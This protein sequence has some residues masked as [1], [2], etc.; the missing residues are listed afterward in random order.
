M[1]TGE[2]YAIEFVSE[3]GKPL[4]HTSKFINQCGVVVRDNVPITV[5]EWKEPK[6]ARLGFSFVDK[7]TKKDC[8]RKLMEHFIL[9]PEY[10]KVDEFGNEVP[11]G[12]QR[13]RL[14]KEFALQ[15]MGEAFRNFKKNLTRDYV[16]KGKTPDFNGQH[17]KLKDDWPEFV[18]QKQSEHFKEISK[19]NKDN[20]SKK[21]FHHIMGPGGY[22]LSEPRWQKMEEDLRVRGIPLGTEGWDPRAKSWW[23]GHGGSLDPETGVCVHRQRQFAPTQALIDAMTQAQE[24][25]IKFNR[26]KDALTTALGNDEHGGRVRGKGKVPW[27]VG[28]SQDNDPYCYRSRKRK[29]DRDADLMTKFA[30]ELHE[31]KQ[32]VHELVKEKSAAGPHEDHE[33]DRGSQQRRSSVAS[34]DAPPG[35]SAPMIEIRAPEPHYPVDDVK[36]MKECDLHYPVGNVSTKVASGSA[37]PCTPGALH[38]NNPIAY[39]YARVTV[40]DIVQGFEDLEIDKPT[41][42]GERRLGDVKRQFIL[43]KKKYI[44]FPGEAPRLASPPP[45]DGGGGGGGGGGGRGGSPTPPSRH[46]TP[47]PDPQPPAGTTPPNPPPAGMTPPNPPPAKKQKQADNKETRSWTINPDPYVPKTTRVPEP[48]LK[49]LLPRPWELSEAETKLAASAHYEKWKAE[50]GRA[51]CRERV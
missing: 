20:A 24:G 22:R 43:W 14:V 45:S 46:S 18:R 39:G 1:K 49:P 2:T 12:R 31:L 40:E 44:V 47:S 21:K 51:S 28:F 26:E 16:N 13:R 3:T 6:K 17:E 35:A 30:S 23:Y 36:E 11:G 27:K 10:N 4:Q 32:T 19:K 41:P 9:P 42:E 15:K 5:Q 38:H 33:A 7:R 50:I 25:L 8:W 29:T 34:T 37:L 48:S